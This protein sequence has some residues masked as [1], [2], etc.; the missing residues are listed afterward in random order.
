[1]C[2]ILF[3]SRTLRSEAKHGI[4]YVTYVMLAYF[5]GTYVLGVNPLTFASSVVFFDYLMLEYGAVIT[6]LGA[7]LGFVYLILAYIY[8]LPMHV[9][10]YA[11]GL[12]WLPSAILAKRSEKRASARVETNRDLLQTAFGILIILILLAI[13]RQRAEFLVASMIMVGYLMMSYARAFSKGSLAK[14]LSKLE[15][16]GASF[17]Q[18]ALALAVGTFIALGQTNTYYAI[19]ILSALFLG[20]SAA[21][22]I[23]MRYGRKKLPWNSKKS[24]AGSI[25]YFIAAAVI[26]TILL[27]YVGIAF[28]A[29]GALL[30]S[31]NVWLDDNI[32][33]PI[34]LAILSVL[35]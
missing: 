25:A 16:N 15:R 2:I 10:A 9:A 17:G 30:E 12:G 27:G 31:F 33:V 24:Y 23:G 19:A 13:D 29:A 22:I 21:T 26:P 8:L 35:A 4:G 20:D 1:M 34:A 14:T 11:I 5:F 28:A 3:V 32:L 7:M 18:G 6:I